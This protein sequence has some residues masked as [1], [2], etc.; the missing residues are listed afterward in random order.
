MGQQILKYTDITD[1]FYAIYVRSYI[2][3]HKSIYMISK[4]RH[5]DYFKKN[6][7]NS[8]CNSADFC[9]SADDMI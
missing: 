3:I 2:D 1:I 9:Y 6:T 8:E 5:G 4:Y 7:A